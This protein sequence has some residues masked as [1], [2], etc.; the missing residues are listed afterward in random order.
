MS[1]DT[2]SHVRVSLLYDE[3][4][5]CISFVFWV[6]AVFCFLVFGCQYQCNRLSTKT[7]LQNDLSH[8]EWDVKPY[9]LTLMTGGLPFC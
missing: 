8:V 7:H 2:S 6:Y 3:L 4:L 1:D 5:F 9:T